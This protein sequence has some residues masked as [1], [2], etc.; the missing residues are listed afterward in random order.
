MNFGLDWLK[1]EVCYFFFWG[2]GAGGGSCGRSPLLGWLHVTCDA[3]FR[4]WP[5]YFSQKSCVKIWFG[6]VEAFKSYRGNIQKKK[7]III[8]IIIIKQNHRCSSKQYLSENSFRADNKTKSQ[9][10]LKAIS[11]G[12]FFPCG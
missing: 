11:F 10:Q 4:I 7:I 5:S 9:A 6:L 12:K 1:S 3:H 8:I 2:G